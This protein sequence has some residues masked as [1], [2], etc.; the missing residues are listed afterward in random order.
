MYRII[1]H[2]L[3]LLSF[4][5]VLAQGLSES[6]IK[7][8]RRIQENLI[9][10]PEKAHAE[11]LEVSHSKNE[12]FRFY[13]N[14]YIANY[15]YNKSDYTS[16]RK[17]LLSLISNIEKSNIPKSSKSVSRFDRYVCQQT[18]LPLQEFRRVRLGFVLFG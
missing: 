10:A 7:I 15:Y 8:T 18:F 9:A 17:Q 3:L 14:Y 13:G 16:S 11:A 4:S 12:L 2:C 5:S 6:E 1:C